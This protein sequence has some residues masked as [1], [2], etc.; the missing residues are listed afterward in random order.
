LKIVGY[1]WFDD[2]VDKLQSKHNVSPPEVQELFLNRPQVRFVEKGHYANENVYFA[3]GQS[4]SGRYLI[5]FFI[6]KQDRR[7]LIISARDMTRA[8]RKQYGRK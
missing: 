8:E 5:V 6:Y 2:I 7:A 4:D 3:M 1:I